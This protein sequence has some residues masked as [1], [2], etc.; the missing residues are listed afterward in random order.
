MSTEQVKQ[1][2][3][4]AFSKM[5]AGLGGSFEVTESAFND[6]IGQSS[7]MPVGE[8]RCVIKA[9]EVV[10]GNYGPQ[11]VVTWEASNGAVIKQYVAITV[12]DQ[13]TKET[14]FAKAYLSLM[15]CLTEDTNFARTYA[16][17]LPRQAMSGKLT[18]VDGLVG[19]V[20]NVVVT[21]GKKGYEISEENKEFFVR[22]VA[23]NELLIPTPFQS[24]KDAAT[25][26]KEE[27]FKRAFN[28]V[29]FLKPIAEEKANNEA[30]L[31]KVIA[32]SK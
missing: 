1:D 8:H 21:K 18:L 22:D 25:V 14:T 29:H 27:G 16:Q 23:T 3:K 13:E 24:V 31:K 11:I 17:E 32:A 12:E 10:V 6:A 28:K 9:A 7:Y 30:G 5:M 2:L 15:S 4:S 20:A 26:A 19:G